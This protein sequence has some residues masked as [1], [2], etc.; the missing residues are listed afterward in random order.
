MCSCL[1]NGNYKIK[2]HNQTNTHL[3][4]GYT[5]VA[6]FRG[7]KG[8]PTEGPFDKTFAKFTYNPDSEWP[9]LSVSANTSIWYPSSVPINI[10]ASDP[11][12]L[13]YI[14]INGPPQSTSSF[15][16]DATANKTYS[17]TA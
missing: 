17:I 13:K 2:Y 3:T 16:Y 6:Y 10:V 8:S 12:G 14:S 15:T 5:Y 1:N 11:S 4:G 7:V 9:S